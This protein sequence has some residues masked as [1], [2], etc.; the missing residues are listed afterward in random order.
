MESLQIVNGLFIRSHRKILQSCVQT[1]LDIDS[2]FNTSV[3]MMMHAIKGASYYEKG[4]EL[5][6]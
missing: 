4:Q 2:A 5:R 1:I 6:N 3:S